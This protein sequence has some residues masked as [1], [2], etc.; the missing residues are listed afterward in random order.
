M[1]RNRFEFHRYLFLLHISP[2]FACLGSTTDETHIHDVII[3]ALAGE[4]SRVLAT[5]NGRV[6]GLDSRHGA[7]LAATG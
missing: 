1:V 7:R 4:A 5:A 3:S 2:S 6:H